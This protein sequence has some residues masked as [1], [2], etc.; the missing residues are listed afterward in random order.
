MHALVQL[1]YDL[2]RACTAKT[3]AILI[4]YCSMYS[5]LNEYYGKSSL[6]LQMYLQLQLASYTTQIILDINYYK[7][8]YSYRLNYCHLRALMITLLNL[9]VCMHVSICGQCYHIAIQLYIDNKRHYIAIVSIIIAI[10]FT[11][12]IYGAGGYKT[13]QLASQ[14][15][16]VH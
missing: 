3:T 13:S 12:T 14:R 15:M 11:A 1:S 2:V 6:T 7:E 5:Y 8:W 10:W 16:L 4:S 9:C